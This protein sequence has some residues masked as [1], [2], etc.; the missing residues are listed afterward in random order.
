MRS[1]KRV[2]AE[3][4]RASVQLAMGD[5]AGALATSRACARPQGF[6]DEVSFSALLHLRRYEEAFALAP[7]PRELTPLVA[8]F[9]ERAEVDGSALPLVGSRLVIAQGG[10]ADGVRFAGTYPALHARSKQLVVTCDPRLVTLLERS[11]P[12]IAFLPVERFNGRRPGGCGPGSPSR[13]GDVFFKWLTAEARERASQCERVLLERSLYH[14]TLD[15]IDAAPYAAYLGPLPELVADFAQRWPAARQRV[16]V[17][18]RSELRGPA[19]EVHYVSPRDVA[20]L[21]RPDDLV[22][23]LQHD[24]TARE[25]EELAGLSAAPVEFVHDVDLRNDFESTAAV[26]SSLDVVVGIGTTMTELSGAV[27]TR[28]L[29]LQPMRL[30][31][32]RA[33]DAA[34]H[35]FWYR[36]TVVVSGDPPSD[37]RSLMQRT[38]DLLDQ[39]T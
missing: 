23:C 22:V 31:T 8:V 30:G 19:R 4:L 27:G 5:I 15:D 13:S 7:N 34:G 26:L 36:S 24:A 37:R 38:G 14:L 28:T 2:E 20:R 10:P 39:A 29:L 25:R 9:G 6:M 35:D 1:P 33:V 16:G 12:D 3:K 18:W 21:F 32:W 11:F 17:V